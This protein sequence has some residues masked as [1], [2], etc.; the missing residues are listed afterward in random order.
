MTIYMTMQI[1]VASRHMP[2]F[3]KYL[4]HFISMNEHEMCAKQIT[5]CI[6]I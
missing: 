2:A 3:S 5:F 1:P 6:V 4:K